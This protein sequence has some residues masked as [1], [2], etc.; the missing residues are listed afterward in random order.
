MLA[1]LVKKVYLISWPMLDMMYGLAIIEGLNS[2]SRILIF[3]D[4]GNILL[5]N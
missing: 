5:T 1:D 2:P 4:I 3:P